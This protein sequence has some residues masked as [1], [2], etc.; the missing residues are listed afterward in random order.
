MNTDMEGYIY[1][2]IKIFT[3]ADVYLFVAISL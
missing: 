3:V 2:Y 1:I